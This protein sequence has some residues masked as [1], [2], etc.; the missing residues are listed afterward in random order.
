MNSI[1]PDYRP[2]NY[3]E[4]LEKYRKVPPKILNVADT[5]GL[6]TATNESGLEPYTGEWTETQQ[7]HLL[8]RA[9]FGVT[10]ADLNEIKGLSLSD[11]IDLL[12]VKGT[13]PVPPVN[14]Y[15]GSDEGI[16]DPEIAFGETWIQSAHGGDYEGPRTIS[17]KGWLIKGFINQ[18]TTLEEKMLLFWHNL[19]PIQTWGVFY[20]KLSYRY[21]EM[22]RRNLYGNYKTMIRELTLDP[23]MLLYLN[24]TFNSKEAPDE[25][26]GRELQ[27]LFC[28]GKGSNANFTEGDVQA[29]ARVLTGW[30]VDWEKFNDSGDLAVRFEPYFHETADKQFSAFY[31]NTLI[32]GRAGSEGAEEL[33]ELL[34]M[35]FNNQETAL[36]ICRRLYKFFVYNDI[37]ENTEQNVIVPLAQLFRDNDYEIKPVLEVLLKSAHFHDASNHGAMIKNPAE[38]IIGLW[39]TLGI[40]GVS[41]G[42]ILAEY[43]QHRGMLWQ[44][45]NLGLEVG[46]PPSVSGWPAYYQA[47]SFDKYW[48]TTDTITNRAIMSDSMCDW[49]FWVDD[50]KQFAAD[51]IAFLQTLD[52]P[53][54]ANEMLRESGKLMLGIPLEQE[55]IDGLKEIL[56]SGQQSDSYWYIAWNQLMADPE[57]DEYRLIVRNRLVPTFKHLLQLGQSHLM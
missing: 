43:E 44:M 45:A 23:A 57:N 7:I 2:K 10:K 55:E 22:L 25:N 42:D 16:I 6:R 46:D 49:G 35:I 32:S 53:E 40:S 31:S 3:T 28:I 39:R 36:Y 4:L 52:Q 8:R 18:P 1:H 17:L 29:S 48:I 47:P 41:Q 19:L 54:E 12:L 34:D 24:G 50:D 26:Y 9:L 51:L 38:F 15:N 20:A 13:A 33:D 37:D 11:T 14:D 27:E 56:L 5:G 21:F 30:I